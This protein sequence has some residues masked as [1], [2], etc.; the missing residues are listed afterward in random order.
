MY[1]Q[2]PFSFSIQMQL[3]R[4]HVVINSSA[5][6]R[7]FLAIAAWSDAGLCS[8]NRSAQALR[9]KSTQHTHSTHTHTHTHTHRSDANHYVLNNDARNLCSAP[10]VRVYAC[11]CLPSAP[12]GSCLPAKK[13]WRL[14]LRTEFPR[15]AGQSIRAACPPWPCSPT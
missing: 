4:S 9:T 12:D 3:P 11:T 1:L 10:H 8:S 5:K 7:T 6:S 14:F 2:C 13:A 15:A